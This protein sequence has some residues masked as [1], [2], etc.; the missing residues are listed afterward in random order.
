MLRRLIFLVVVAV[1]AASV[2]CGYHLGNPSL[3]GISSVHIGKVANAT[4]EPRLGII[5]ASK[6]RSAF[7]SDGTLRLDDAGNADSELTLTVSGYK[8]GTAGSA[9]L[10][11]DDKDQR[12][13][14]TLIYRVTVTVY[15]EF[16][17][18]SGVRKGK[19]TGVAEFSDLI[20]I[21]VARRDG[22]QQAL[23]DAGK[24]LVTN[25]VNAW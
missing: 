10:A 9:K 22:L 8:V 11:S 20:D 25:V 3:N 2:G 24:K 1:S 14:S 4:D 5:A 12:I 17:G 19:V 7:A 21:N 16:T 6:V 13:Y 15:Y 23:E 18:G